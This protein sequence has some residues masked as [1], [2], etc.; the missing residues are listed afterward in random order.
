MAMTP[1]G[2]PCSVRDPERE[3]YASMLKAQVE[4]PDP[5]TTG[6]GGGLY[7]QGDATVQ[8]LQSKK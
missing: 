7:L 4:R 2:E 5:R 1:R 8:D 3:A 6:L